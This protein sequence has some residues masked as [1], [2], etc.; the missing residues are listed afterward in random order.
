MK[1]PIII[2][3][4]CFVN[5]LAIKPDIVVSKN[6]DGDFKFIQEAL[7]SILPNNSEFKIIFIKSGVYNE[8]I[9]IENNNIA[10]IGESREDVIIIYAELRRSWRE[11]N[12]SDYGASVINIKNNVSDLFFHNLTIYNNYGSLY[13]DNDHQFAI[14]GGEGVTRI[15]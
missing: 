6:G 8:K 4:F 12:D 1:L 2:I 10:L 7:N 5:I 9:F 13:G 11:K 14:R 15:I 3:L